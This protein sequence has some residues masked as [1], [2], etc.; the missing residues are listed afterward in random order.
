MV[1]I[2]GLAVAALVVA[3]ASGSNAASGSGSLGTSSGPTI[4]ITVPGSGQA[5]FSGVVGGKDLTGTVVDGTLP[6]TGA[7]TGT[8]ALQAPVFTYR[9]SF[10]GAPYVLHVSLD[11][12]EATGQLQN[13]Q[14]VFYVTGTYGSEPVTASAT[15]N[16]TSVS[17]TSQKVTFNGHV[18]SQSITGVVTATM[19][20]GGRVTIIGNVNAVPTA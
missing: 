8:L 5:G 15:F 13:D 11:E 2:L 6:A 14:F 10:D 7:D 19:E 20:A 1:V 17:G 4:D 3:L 18:G 16:L 12:G 9:G